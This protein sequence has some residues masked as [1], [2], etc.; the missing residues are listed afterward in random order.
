MI[1]LVSLNIER[2]KH[3]DRVI[4]FLQQQH[5]DIVCLQ[6]LVETDIPIFEQHIGS[7]AVYAQTSFHPAD[8]PQTGNVVDCNG[9]FT[10]LP[11]LAY[12]T[13]FYAGD[14]EQLPKQ[15]GTAEENSR[16]E[17]NRL[18]SFARVGKD[19]ETFT[20]AT[21]HFTWS[22]K[23]AATDLQRKDMTSL[24][25]KLELI[26]ECV[27]CGDFNAPRGGEIFQMLADRYKDNIPE[28]YKTSIDVNLHRAGKFPSEKMDEKMVD[29]LF[30]TPGYVVSDVELHA[31]VSDHMA[32]TAT[33][34]RT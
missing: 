12:D 6:E 7:C 9:I 21:T 23:G 18:L 19:P 13:V 11:V 10:R 16:T 31:G 32:I 29:G 3:L 27:L 33:I 26:G 1:K 24:L 5:A 14:P 17:P 22:Y 34:S 28:K 2:S 8:A 25:Q 15:T 4:P 20:V 30:T